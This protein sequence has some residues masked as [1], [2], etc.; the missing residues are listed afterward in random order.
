MD[1]RRTIGIQYDATKHIWSITCTMINVFLR[2][3]IFFR[4]PELYL[5]G[6]LEMR[7]IYER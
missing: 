1:L 3:V 2:P 4:Q 7:I 5:C 6:D